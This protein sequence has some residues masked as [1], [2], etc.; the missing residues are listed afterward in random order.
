MFD[1]F[2]KRHFFFEI[3]TKNVVAGTLVLSSFL[4]PSSLLATPKSDSL[5]FTSFS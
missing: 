2:S 5:F 1:K 4:S 3:C